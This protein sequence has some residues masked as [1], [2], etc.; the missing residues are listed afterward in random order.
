MTFGFRTKDDVAYMD[1]VAANRPE[2]P[3]KATALPPE[4]RAYRE[5]AFSLIPCKLKLS[6]DGKSKEMARRPPK[7]AD[8]RTVDHIYDL[9]D[10]NAWLALKD[11][12]L[13]IDTDSEAA[14]RIVDGWIVIGI[15]PQPDMIVGTYK[16]KHYY[17]RKEG[18]WH[19]NQGGMQVGPDDNDVIDVI[20]L[21]SNGVYCAG[22]W[23]P[24]AKRRYSIIRW[25][26][27]WG[28]ALS[29]ETLT[30]AIGS[31]GQNGKVSNMAKTP[32]KGDSPRVGPDA[33]KG[34]HKTLWA[35][36]YDMWYDQGI[37]NRQTIDIAVRARHAGFDDPPKE[38][39]VAYISYAIGYGNRAEATGHPASDSYRMSKR[40]QAVASHGR[41][42]K[43][44]PPRIDQAEI[45]RMYA[46]GSTQQAIAAEL[47]CAQSFVSKALKKIKRLQSG[48]GEIVSLFENSSFFLSPTTSRVIIVDKPP[49]TKR[50]RPSKRDKIRDDFY[51]GGCTGN[52]VDF[53]F[54]IIQAGDKDRKNGLRRTQ[55]KRAWLDAL[56]DRL[57]RLAHLERL[58]VAGKASPKERSEMYGTSLEVA[59]ALKHG[60]RSWTGAKWTM[61]WSKDEAREMHEA[62]AAA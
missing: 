20:D 27:N 48:G 13:V 15:L 40:R 35:L 55:A 39:E 17:Y 31:L 54:K 8:W 60:L 1:A 52:D 4:V 25:Q 7:H 36:A 14:D 23:H 6:G 50:G 19:C 38:D 26:P 22:S 57:T 30:A 33:D 11:G 49:S 32:P 5:L 59:D 9:P 45:A 56:P 16:G 29:E 18:D 21:S 44:K 51:E 37:H 58:H 3:P 2:P 43:R 10:A 62:L 12:W 46:E 41:N 28:G 53:I 47:G 42:S 34:R 61:R 24:V